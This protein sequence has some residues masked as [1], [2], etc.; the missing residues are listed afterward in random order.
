MLQLHEYDEGYSTDI[1]TGSFQQALAAGVRFVMG[2]H[3]ASG[4]YAVIPLAKANNIIY[5]DAIAG[6]DEAT[7]PGYYDGLFN[8]PTQTKQSALAFCGWLTQQGYKKIGVLGLNV[9]YGQIAQGWADYYVANHPGTWTIVNRTWYQWGQTDV[10]AEMAPI[11]A[12]KPDF[13]WLYVYSGAQAI[14]AIQRIR[15]LGY[16]GPIAT[17]WESL[18]DGSI[19]AADPTTM[20]GVYSFTGWMPD[21]SIPQAMDF[22]NRYEAYC[23]SKGLGALQPGDYAVSEYEGVMAYSK[24]VDAVG[25]PD[26]NVAVAK[27]I[28]ALSNTTWITPR[29]IQFQMLPGGLELDPGMYIQQV[30]NGK[31]IKADFFPLTVADFGPPYV[32]TGFK[33]LLQLEQEAQGNTTSQ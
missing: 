9:D 13:I 2:P 26:D 25:S 30:H 31:V 5:W 11:V 10:T 16:T 14:P 32:P 8:S 20:E 33:T 6:T 3:E 22:Y 15:E 18:S 19:A 7:V 29:G 27:A 17:D 1:A 12:A 28:Y 24:A 21:P 23:Q 4:A